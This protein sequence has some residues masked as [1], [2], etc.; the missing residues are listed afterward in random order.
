[1]NC[2]GNGKT[3]NRFGQLYHFAFQGRAASG[4]KPRSPHREEKRANFVARSCEIDSDTQQ[5]TDDEDLFLTV[6]SKVDST[7]LSTKGQHRSR[8][9]H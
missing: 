2:P 1:M 9:Q 6:T 3:C 7:V 8:D 4:L 5:S